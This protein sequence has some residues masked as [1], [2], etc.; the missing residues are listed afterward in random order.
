[1]LPDDETVP[2]L[3]YEGALMSFVRVVDYLLVRVVSA[4]WHGLDT[5]YRCD[6]LE[7]RR[8]CVCHLRINLP[9]PERWFYLSDV[10]EAPPC[11]AT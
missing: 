6:K 7:Q 3:N 10:P 11:V 8:F 9:P 4:G 1:M 5:C 2:S